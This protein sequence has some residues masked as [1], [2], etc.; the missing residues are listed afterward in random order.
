MCK[1]MVLIE[2]CGEYGATI[3]TRK[4]SWTAIEDAFFEKH[5]C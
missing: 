5:G 1:V 3:G 2:P 4:I